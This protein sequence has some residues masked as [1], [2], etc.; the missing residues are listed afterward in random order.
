MMK[1]TCSDFLPGNATRS[2]WE[3]IGSIDRTVAKIRT[4]LALE[5]AM[6]DPE[7]KSEMKQRL[8]QFIVVAFLSY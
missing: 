5:F 4:K 7:Y 1:S 6:M 2:V 8:G 3:E